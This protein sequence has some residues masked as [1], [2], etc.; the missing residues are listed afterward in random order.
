[1]RFPALPDP[2]AP[3]LDAWLRALDA[4][5][6]ALGAGATV[7]CHSLGCL[8]WLHHAAGDPGPPAPARVL[9]VAPP[10]P[11]SP[12]A[13]VA[14][15]LPPP[16]DPAP[17]ARA[18]RVTRLV[19]ADDDPYCPEGALAAYAEPLGLPAE[20]VPGGGHL[21]ADAGLGPWPALERWTRGGGDGP[22]GGR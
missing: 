7:L 4:E 16:L 11:R 13:E 17:V 6:A 19:A 15:F 22:V 21:N 20:V 8:L 1:V 12:I 9:L 14:G 5:R 2:D 3:R 18:A 10:S